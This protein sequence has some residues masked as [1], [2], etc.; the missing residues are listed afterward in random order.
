MMAFCLLL[1]QF[2]DVV[3]IISKAV[4][5]GT[6]NRLI[7]FLRKGTHLQRKNEHSSYSDKTSGHYNLNLMLH[8]SAL[9]K[10]AIL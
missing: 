2:A 9:K 7:L 10:Q 1:E 3:I 5:L 4:P 8:L 6:L